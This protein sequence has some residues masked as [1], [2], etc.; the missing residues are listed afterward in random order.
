MQPIEGLSKDLTLLIIAHRHTTLKNC[1][2]IVALGD[3]GIE[4]CGSYQD[5]LTSKT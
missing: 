2:Q 4:R 5:M 3:G 1:K